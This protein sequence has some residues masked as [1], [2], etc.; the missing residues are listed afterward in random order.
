M[1]NSKTIASII[2]TIAA[3]N[4]YKNMTERHAYESRIIGYEIPEIENDF[5]I[6][7]NEDRNFE[8]VKAM[9]AETLLKDKLVYLFGEKLV[10]KYTLFNKATASS[11]RYEWLRFINSDEE[12]PF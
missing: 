6:M 1:T 7:I 10:D 11:N 4:T 3:I 2:V 9:E 12:L 5:W 8:E